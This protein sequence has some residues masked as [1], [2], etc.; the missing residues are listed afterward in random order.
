MSMLLLAIFLLASKLPKRHWAN[1]LIARDVLGVSAT[2][3]AHH[4]V[5]DE[6]CQF[7]GKTT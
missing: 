2:F 4:G 6:Y 3:T 5:V 7:V 1:L